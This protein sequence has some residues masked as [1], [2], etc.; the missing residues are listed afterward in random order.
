MIVTIDGPGGSGKSTAARELARRIGFRF[1]NTGAM[2]RAVALAGIRA[3]VDW[4]RPEEL[5]RVAQGLDLRV[6][7]DR[8]F[9]GEEDVT[10]LVRTPAVDLMTRHAADNVPIRRH[11]VA[12]QRLAVREDNW[13][14]EGR[15]QGTDAFPEAECKVFLTASTA[16]RAKR[17][18][19][20]L[21]RLGEAASYDEVLQALLNRDQQDAGREVGALRRAPDSI[22]LVTDGLSIAEVVE[23]LVKIVRSRMNR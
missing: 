20:E 6:D 12:L 10:G 8:V 16:V 22:E 14:T 23:K 21:A 15:D 1:L 7:D 5:V 9:L 3:G 2:Y 13:V 17:R 4:H 19:E 11:L 18:H